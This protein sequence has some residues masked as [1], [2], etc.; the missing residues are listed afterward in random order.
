MGFE[1]EPDGQEAWTERNLGSEIQ[2]I[3][4]NKDWTEWGICCGD[5][6][7]SPW[8]WSIFSANHQ[9][10]ETEKRVLVKSSI[11][12]LGKVEVERTVFACGEFVVPGGSHLD[13]RVVVNPPELHCGILVGLANRQRD[14]SLSADCQSKSLVFKNNSDLVEEV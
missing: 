5:I 7:Q 3:L 4:G 12:F 14:R 10:V 6:S 8:S 13:F 11:D 1:V 2:D 9:T